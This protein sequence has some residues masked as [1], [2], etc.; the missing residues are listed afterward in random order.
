MSEAT[1]MT[2]P[3]AMETPPPRPLPPLPPSS[4]SPPKARL[5]RIAVSRTDAV[6]HALHDR[7]NLHFTPDQATVEPG[8]LSDRHSEQVARSG[9]RAKLVDL[10]KK[11]D[12]LSQRSGI[13][14]A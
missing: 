5:W 4:P 12:I 8:L 6:P 11:L 9:E 3:A 1:T 14:T 13:P 7:Y 10:E 2:V